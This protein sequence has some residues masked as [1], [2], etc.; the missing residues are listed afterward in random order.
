M[1]TTMPWGEEIT[2]LMELGF[3]VN[4]MELDDPEL[5][6]LGTAIL[7]GTLIG[8]DLSSYCQS[9]RIGRGRPDQL[10]NFNAGSCVIELNNNDRRFD[11]INQDSPYWDA[12]QGR[13]GVV[14]RRKVTVRSGTDDLFVGLIT[15]V[16]V[17]Y[18]PTKSGA[19]YDLSTVQITAADDFVLLANTFTES[20]ITPT[21]ELSGARVESILDLPEVAYPLTR[22]ID[23]GIATLGG[24]ATFE[25]AANTN[26]LTYLQ[27]V[28]S[29][30]QGYF[31]IAANGN[32]VFTDRVGATFGGA[33]VLFADDG[34]EVPYTALQ[35]IY[36]QEFLY[37]KVVASITGGTE[38]IANDVAS[39]AEYGIST[40][41][42]D[43]LLLSTD[44]AALELAQ[45]LL[46]SYSQ[47][48]YR[49]D[50]L[51][52]E[53]MTLTGVQQTALSGLELGDIVQVKRTYNTGT[54]A[55]VEL[56]FSIEAISHSIT[57]SGH[58]IE[59][60]L[61]YVELIYPFTL[62]DA[63]LG[64]LDENNAL[65]E[66]TPLLPFFFDISEFDS[67]FSFQ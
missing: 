40:L 48:Q 55:F 42:L 1:A 16:D 37:N 33:S 41:S 63:V 24:G 32:L 26:V 36:G 15:D 34:T 13:S 50:R 67:G 44:A 60:G 65:S 31:Y 8:D 2:V 45:D 47:P 5:A 54:P 59:L 3:P 6:A 18:S 64:R 22:S 14:P 52:T 53:F 66:A 58:S 39:Q 38:Q 28:A 19:S 57:P 25:I 21:E 27:Q 35:V 51:R 11:P 17:S 49:F 30:E 20:A 56:Q 12:E 4:G 7:D 23:T 10:Q 62:D 29:S 46:A 61:A 9:I 43:E